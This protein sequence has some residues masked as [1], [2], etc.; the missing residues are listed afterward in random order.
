MNWVRYSH[1][2]A[3][4]VPS[5]QTE[6]HITISEHEKKTCLLPVNS[7]Y[8]TVQHFQTV[9]YAN[10][11]QHIHLWEFWPSPSSLLCLSF[12]G[13]SPCMPQLIV[14]SRVLCSVSYRVRGFCWRTAVLSAL[15]SPKV[16]Q[17]GTKLSGGTR[18][19]P[20]RPHLQFKGKLANQTLCHCQRKLMLKNWV[21]SV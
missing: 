16:T 12:P 13:L 14:F 9:A 1:F 19:A 4:T 10:E 11:S 6:K 18:K 20:R 8:C 2:Q 21:T 15:T 5:A 17:K 3:F 7:P